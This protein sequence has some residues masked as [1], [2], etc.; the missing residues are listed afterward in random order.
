MMNW[1]S[2][3]IAVAALCAWREARGEGPEGMRAVL[4]A[5]R[6]RVLSQKFGDWADVVCKKWQFSSMTAPGDPELILWPRTGDKQFEDAYALALTVFCGT[7]PDNTHAATHYFAP[8][9]VLPDWAAKMVKVASIGH[10]DFYREASSRI[11]LDDGQIV[12]F[13]RIGA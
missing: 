11:L 7:D 3:Y 5:M 1:A 10:H 6:N 2:W 12:G 9:S 4:H 8:A 13:G